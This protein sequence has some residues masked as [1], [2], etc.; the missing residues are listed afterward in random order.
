MAAFNA[1]NYID[2]AIESVINQTYRNFELLI[3]DDASSDATWLVANSY[4]DERIKV[5]KNARNSG[6][7]SA[8]NLALGHASGEY[9][10]II[11]ADDFY[12]PS[13]LE[14]LVSHVK[15]DRNCI[16]AD[17]S[18]LF[19][20]LFN[21]GPQET[22]FMQQQLVFDESGENWLTLEGFFSCGFPNIKPMFPLSWVKDKCLTYDERIGFGEDLKFMIDL[23]HSGLHLKLINEKTYFYRQTPS[24][25]TK[26]K[27]KPWD[28]LAL[29]HTYAS[30]RF[31]E[32]GNDSWAKICRNTSEK[33]SAFDKVKK[34]NFMGLLKMFYDKPYVAGL[35]FNGVRETFE[36][37]MKD[38]RIKF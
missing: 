15:A 31:R 3:V 23:M 16:V 2:E 25:I 7:S 12:Q 35:L 8:R 18:V 17:D 4:D 37:R 6:P 14:M 5:Y 1:E 19:T 34:R 9:A 28:Q 30:E 21:D 11:D 36:Y 13:R 29:V 26:N 27:R 10:T 38:G 20:S 32:Q 22:V 33:Y 24:S